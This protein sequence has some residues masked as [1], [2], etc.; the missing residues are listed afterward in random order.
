[1]ASNRPQKTWRTGYWVD[2]SIGSDEPAI[3]LLE[4]PGEI[5]AGVGRSSFISIKGD[6]ISMSGGTPSV[7]SIQGL[8]SSMKYA[9]MIQDLPW[10]LTMMP[11][12]TF[13]PLPKQIIVPPMLDELPMI[14]QVASIATSLAGF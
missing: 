2:D 11:S 10:P 3:S 5:R 4:N 7:I 1:M 8:S 9:G 13:T 14:Q 6:K 12:T